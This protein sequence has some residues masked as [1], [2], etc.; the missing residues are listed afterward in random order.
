MIEYK[1]ERSYDFLKIQQNCVCDVW[2][3]DAALGEGCVDAFYFIFKK[4]IL[5]TR[6][7]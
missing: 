3:M 2:I 6:V 1:K 7:Q 4:T 5:R